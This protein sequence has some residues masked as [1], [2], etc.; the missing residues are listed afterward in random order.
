[1]HQ[2]DVVRALEENP[3]TKHGANDEDGEEAGGFAWL[4]Q[5][6]SVQ[7]SRN[8]VGFF[9]NPKTFFC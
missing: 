6:R 8:Y 9:L 2:R 7:T 5:L 3:E 4:A 1:M